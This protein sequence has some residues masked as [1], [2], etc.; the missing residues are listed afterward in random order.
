[1]NGTTFAFDVPPVS[2]PGPAGP[3]G[4]TTIVRVPAPS[5]GSGVLGVQAKSCEGDDLVTLH[6]PR[7]AGQRFLSARATIAGKRL[8]VCGRAITL[9][10][11]GRS[12]GRYDVRIVA[13][14]RTRSGR[15]V[16]RVTHRPRSV[17]CA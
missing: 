9:D 4:M 14:Y 5:P 12:G 1:V 17:A 8:K 13:R 16:T 10:L 11:R 7:R 15:V 6:V 3:A 2:T